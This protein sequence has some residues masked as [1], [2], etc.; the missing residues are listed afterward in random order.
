MGLQWESSFPVYCWVSGA[1][2]EKLQV[3]LGGRQGNLLLVATV[4]AVA[5]GLPGC[6]GTAAAVVMA[7]A[8]VEKGS[9]TLDYCRRQEHFLAAAFESFAAAA[10]LIGTLPFQM[11]TYA[12]DL[13]ILTC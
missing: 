13:Q 6:G 4:T 1:V 10:D 11:G 8:G 2:L 9:G 12:V 3:T 5:S 7:R